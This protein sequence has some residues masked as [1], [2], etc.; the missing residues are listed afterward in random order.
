MT[1]ITK[2]SQQAMQPLKVARAAECFVE[3]FFCLFVFGGS[4]IC[5]MPLDHGG[6]CYKHCADGRATEPL[7]NGAALKPMVKLPVHKYGWSVS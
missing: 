1:E 3:G 6:L 7:P 5:T 4:F 2:P